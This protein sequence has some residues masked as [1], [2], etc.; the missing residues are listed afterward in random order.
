MTATLSRRALVLSSLGLAAA[1]LLSGCGLLREE[2]KVPDITIADGG[3][4]LAYALA[5]LGERYGEGFSQAGGTEVTSYPSSYSDELTYELCA[6]PTADPEK[7]FGCDI[8]TVA[9]T[10]KLADVLEDDYTQ[11]RRQAHA[12]LRGRPRLEARRAGG[13]PRERLHAARGDGHAHAAR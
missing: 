2:K 11:Y 10:G 4:A 3:D 12:A 13:L 8:S 1:S 7:V 9:S 6:C 5:A